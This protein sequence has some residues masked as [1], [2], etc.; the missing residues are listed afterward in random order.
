MYCFTVCV[1]KY[2]HCCRLHSLYCYNYWY[3]T[4]VLQEIKNLQL[5]S[6]Y[7]LEW[8]SCHL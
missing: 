2:K 7:L 4:I 1:I 6:D 5:S 3:I 8:A